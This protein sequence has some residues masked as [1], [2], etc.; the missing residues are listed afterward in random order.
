M[1]PDTLT[2][3]EVKIQ[4]ILAKQAAINNKIANLLILI[5]RYSDTN[6]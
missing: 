2:E 5:R 3:N 6:N 1:N 4:T